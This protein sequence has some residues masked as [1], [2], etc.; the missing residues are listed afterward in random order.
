MVRDFE[1]VRPYAL[2]PETEQRLLALQSECVFIWRN[3]RGEPVGVVQSFF[4][5]GGRIWMTTVE[6]RKRVAAV[7][8]CPHTSVCVTSLG[9]SLG[10]GKS[11]TYI[12]TTLVHPPQ[13]R[14]LK[15]WFFPRFIA[16]RWGAREGEHFRRLMGALDTPHRVILEFAP[17][18]KIS[19]D[20]SKM[21]RETGIRLQP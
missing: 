13:D 3:S 2:D 5:E 6:T 12:G 18:R 21:E 15:E 10:A 17:K 20:R 4:H 19:H 16:K 11:V 14:S 9:T 7:R 1:D 8:R